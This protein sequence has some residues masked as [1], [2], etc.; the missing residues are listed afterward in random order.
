[1]RQ[2]LRSGEE[3]IAPQRQAL[4]QTLRL[5][6]REGIKLPDQA[7]AQRLG[8]DDLAQDLFWL[9]CAPH[10]DGRL[11][12]ILQ[13]Q[14]DQSW[15]DGALA[16]KLLGGVAIADHALRRA[17][18]PQ[19]PLLRH[20]LL[21]L[22]PRHG[23]E[24]NRMRHELVPAQHALAA[25]DGQRSS[26]LAPWGCASALKPE[27]NLR[28]VEFDLY[29]TQEALEALRGF[30]QRPAQAEPWFGPQGIQLPRGLGVSITAP[31]GQGAAL[32]ARALAGQL[33]WPVLE[34]HAEILVQQRE[35]HQWTH[36]LFQEAHLHGELLLVRD[37][38][39]VGAVG[40]ELAPTWAHCLRSYPVAVA[41]C[42]TARPQ[43]HPDLKDGVQVQVSPARKMDARQQELLWQLHMP[44]EC[45]VEDGALEAL[46]QKISLLPGQIRG[47]SRLLHL[48]GRREQGVVQIDHESLDKVARQQLQQPSTPLA[49]VVE[50]HVT[51][52]DVIL[53]PET[54][55]EI[56]ALVSAIRSRRQIMEGWG[57]RTALGRGL[58][59]SA[60]FDGDPGTGKTLAAEAIAGQCQMSLMQ[61]D[62]STI[63][64]KYIGETEK[65]LTEL[66]SQAR[67][68]LHVLLF[69][70]ADSLFG[71]RTEVRHATDRY[72]N[73]NINTLLQL[74]ER[75]EGI[76]I[77]TTNL[78]KSIDPAFE[79]RLTFKIN[80]PK[81]QVDQRR[82]IWRRLLRP[83]LQTGEPIEH[84]ALAE[85]ELTGG[86]I[87]NA[88][89]KAAYQAA[90]EGKLLD[91]DVLYQAALDEARG[92]G[93]LIR[94]Y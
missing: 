31:R 77:L 34:V 85:V 20:G 63:I 57:L 23:R 88:L 15:V 22:A 4:W 12:Q 61:V 78:K 94:A 55:E 48:T 82:A 16:H 2:W 72:A 3:A 83:P 32:C 8:L 66:F 79:R 38:D 28:Q 30:R 71:K 80:F 25:L 46:T 6:R 68:D 65:N 87:K 70:E 26:E 35:A 29:S 14:H 18:D 49:K 21:R 64:D 73:M 51:L 5:A 10:L 91:T 13:T 42:S 53:P 41:L 60:L 58:G 93:R 36:R 62:T 90:R 40:S 76:T 67:P 75:Y 74:I 69:D 27:V 37:A 9:A 84:G 7:W 86:E 17:L 39:L 56:E 33:Q 45:S 24:P 54:Q 11:P 44:G 19:A 81:P 47:A 89:L 43:W 92:A 1:M 50:H 52:Q 59:L